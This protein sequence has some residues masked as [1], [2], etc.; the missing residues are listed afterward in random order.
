MAQNL[1]EYH[2][3]DGAIFTF[4]VAAGQ[5]VKIGE[6]VEISGNQT[7]SPAA[8]GSTKVVGIVYSGTVGIDGVGVGYSGDQKHVVSVVALKPI[9]YAKAAGAIAA[10]DS[11]QTAG[12]GKQV[13]TLD[14]ATATGFEKIGMALTG[15]SAAGEEVIVMLG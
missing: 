14:T 9:V 4:K 11:L 7:V 5:T 1:V 12:S 10:G 6:F 15:A 13:A 8:D 2:I 3:Q